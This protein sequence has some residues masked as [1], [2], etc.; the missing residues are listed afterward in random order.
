MAQSGTLGIALAACFLSLT[1][2]IAACGSAEAPHA[3][4]TPP[5]AVATEG[6]PPASVTIPDRFQAL[7]AEIEARLSTFLQMLPPAPNTSSSA[8]A[9]GAELLAANGNAGR[10][11]LAPQAMASVRFYLDQLMRLGVRGVTVQIS[12]PLL[13]PD[14]PDSADYLQFYREV[15]AEVRRRGLLLVVET[16]P[17]FSGTI[18]SGLEI[19]DRWATA[20]EY[21]QQRRQ[22]LVIIAREIR[23]D[24]LSL[25]NEPDT[26]RML[27]G[28]SFGLEEY[29][30]FLRDT[31]KEIRGYGSVRLGAGTGTWDDPNYIKRFIEETPLDFIN[32]HI[33]PLTNGR[34]DYL[35]RAIDLT[36]LAKSHGKEVI[37]GE[38]WLYKISATEIQ[39][40]TPYVEAYARDN[41]SFWAPLDARFIEVL[42][43]LAQQE[44]ISYVSF[45]WSK[46]FFGYLPYDETTR[47]ASPAELLKLSNRAA[48]EAMNRSA[49]TAAGAAL[50]RL[51][52]TTKAR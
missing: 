36:R 12:D 44:G 28:L 52:S 32:L 11:L 42:G 14:F 15:A 51:A 24:Y 39:Q 25:G 23:P 45:F 49:I 38:T 6:A 3:S 19:G 26:E 30:E 33:Y 41:F 34:Q 16:G 37:I 20:K 48:V 1:I 8:T 17:V 4:P 29:M 10:A 2:A 40:R 27:T 13:L 22:Q 43:R 21:F 35:L 9:F 31:V 5:T 18:Y 46:F 50:Q 47:A 7:A